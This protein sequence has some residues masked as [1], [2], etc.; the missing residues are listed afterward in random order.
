MHAW[1]VLKGD[2]PPAIETHRMYYDI[3]QRHKF[4]P[5][6]FFPV[7]TGLRPLLHARTNQPPLLGFQG[8]LGFL[9]AAA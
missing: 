3:L 8:Q 4:F 6:A 7:S 9:A 1:Q 2:L 5:E